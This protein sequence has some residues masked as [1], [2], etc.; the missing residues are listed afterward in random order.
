MLD[1]QRDRLPDV[2]A[3]VG[4]DARLAEELVLHEEERARGDLA[5]VAAVGFSTPR[6]GSG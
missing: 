6:D 2:L 4:E 1:R 3:E 5:E